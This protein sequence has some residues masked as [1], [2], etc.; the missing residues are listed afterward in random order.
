MKQVFAIIESK[1][2]E[3]VNAQGGRSLWAEI[4]RS[5]ELHGPCGPKDSEKGYAGGFFVERLKDQGQIQVR[6]HL[7]CQIW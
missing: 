2:V 4:M 6:E 5:L 7:F 3:A 1:I